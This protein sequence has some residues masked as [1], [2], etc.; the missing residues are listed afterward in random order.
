[1]RTFDPAD[2]RWLLALYP[3]LYVA[4][5]AAMFLALRW[6]PPAVAP[7]RGFGTA[8][9]AFGGLGTLPAYLLAAVALFDRLRALRA[10]GVLAVALAPVVGTPLSLVGAGALG[11]H[12]GRAFA[13]LSGAVLIAAL[14]LGSGATLLAGYALA[15]AVPGW[16]RAPAI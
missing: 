12:A 10:P 14:L 3:V 5:T 11:A 16:R 13:V 8:L 15:R 1:M 4:A 6:T 9:L 7:G 2:A